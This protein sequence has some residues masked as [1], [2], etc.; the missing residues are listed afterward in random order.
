MPRILVVHEDL[1]VVRLMREAFIEYQSPVL[2]SQARSASNAHFQLTRYY[3]KRGRW[4]VLMCNGM[5]HQEGFGL[6]RRLRSDQRF[7]NIP[8]VILTQHVRAQ[9]EQR[10]IAIG[11]DFYFEM[12]ATLEGYETIVRCCRELLSLPDDDNAQVT[13]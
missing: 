3:D 10:A 12:P 8:I 5:H 2:I 7:Q 9:D 11:A 1:A 6:L 13:G 4:L